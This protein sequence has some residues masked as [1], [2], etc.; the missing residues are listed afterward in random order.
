[1]FSSTFPYVFI[2]VG[3]MKTMNFSKWIHQKIAWSHLYSNY[4]KE[5]LKIWSDL[6]CWVIKL[7]TTKRNPLRMRIISG[8]AYSSS[9]ISAF[10]WTDILQ[11]KI[12]LS[13]SISLDNLGVFCC[14]CCR[15]FTLTDHI[16]RKHQIPLDYFFIAYIVSLAVTDLLQKYDFPCA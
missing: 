8:I 10:H 15:E 12:D 4:Y 14:H 7:L 5:I 16:Y 6:H 2:K 3:I 1:M 11:Q 9:D 13:I